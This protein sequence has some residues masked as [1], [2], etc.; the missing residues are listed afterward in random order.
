MIK[1]FPDMD[2][3]RSQVFINKF[4]KDLKNYKLI[5]VPVDLL[6]DERLIVLVDVELN[7]FTV[8]NLSDL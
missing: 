2:E 8:F 6:K 5:A 3:K 4:G 1:S 7:K